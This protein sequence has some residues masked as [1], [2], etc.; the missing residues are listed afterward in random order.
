MASNNSKA[1]E[2]A[3]ALRGALQRLSEFHL[4]N[5]GYDIV[6]VRNDEGKLIYIRHTLTVEARESQPISNDADLPQPEYREAK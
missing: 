4:V 1:Q 3:D 2:T 5:V 6:P